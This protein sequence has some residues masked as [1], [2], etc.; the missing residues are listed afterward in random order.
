[1]DYGQMEAMAAA[2]GQAAKDVNDVQT[3]MKN[4]AQKLGGGG[5]LGDAGEGFKDAI[6]SVLMVKL[7]LLEAKLNELQRDIKGAVAKTRDGVASA[8]SRFHD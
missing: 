6:E 1:M 3:Q 2:Y 5:L 7:I 4:V 8:E